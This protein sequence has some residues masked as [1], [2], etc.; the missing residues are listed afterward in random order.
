MYHN[1]ICHALDI[2]KSS[3]FTHLQKS[4][5]D[6]NTTTYGSER[7]KRTESDCMEG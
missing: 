6:K 7:A 2:P 3:V 4:T 1:S 5:L